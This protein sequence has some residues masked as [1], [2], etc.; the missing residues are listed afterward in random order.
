MNK[1]ISKFGSLVACL[2][3]MVT[4]ANVNSACYFLFHQPELPNGAK[5]FRKF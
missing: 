5:K 1:L 4:V 3:L 2:A